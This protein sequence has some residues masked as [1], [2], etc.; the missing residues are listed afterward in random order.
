M[1]LTKNDKLAI[2]SIVEKV[3]E[4]K[5]EEKIIPLED[6]IDQV[7]TILDG[8][9]GNVQNMQ[10]ELTM[11]EGHKDQLEDHQERITALESPVPANI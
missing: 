10:Q 5:F 1:P 8:F 2:E 6:K 7:L 4:E 3:F 11:V 9:A